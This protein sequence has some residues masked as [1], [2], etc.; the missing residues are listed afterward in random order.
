MK[1]ICEN[2][3]FYC[4]LILWNR[5]GMNLPNYEEKSHCCTLFAAEGQVHQCN[6]GNSFCECFDLKQPKM[7]EK[8]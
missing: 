3:K 1:M 4:D 5:G 2:C 7:K 6:S 8:T